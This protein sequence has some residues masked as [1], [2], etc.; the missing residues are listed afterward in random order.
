[1]VLGLA[2]MVVALALNRPYD[3]T[4]NVASSDLLLLQPAAPKGWSITDLPLGST[5]LESGESA[6][7]LNFSAH[8][9]KAYRCGRIEIQLYIAYWQPGRLDPSLVEVHRPETCWPGS[10]A[11]QL[12]RNANFVLR[13]PNGNQTVPGLE[14]LFE[15]PTA[16][17]DVVYW[18]LYGSRVANFARHRTR[19]WSTHLWP[20]ATSLLAALKP[21]GQLVYRLSTNGNLDE[22]TRTSLWPGLMASLESAGLMRSN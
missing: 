5:E 15:F 16:T 2:A 10:G 9:Y 14:G 21:K 13:S 11:V 8:I 20:M 7:T 4:Y 22:L 18:H 1:M 19:F 3:R 17:V 6:K 12:E